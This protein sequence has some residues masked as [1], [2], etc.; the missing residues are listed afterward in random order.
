MKVFHWSLSDSKSP[1]VSRTLLSILAYLSNAVL[2][3]LSAPFISNSSSPFINLLVTIPRAPIIIGITV[4][5]IIHIFFR[6]LVRLKYLFFFSLY[7]NFT[8]YSAVSAKSTIMQVLF[9]VDYFKVWSSGR[10]WAILLY[11]KIPEE[12]VH[13]ILQ[14]RCWV[15]HIPF[16]RMVKL[17]FLAQFLI[18]HLVPSVMSRLKLFLASFAYYV[19]DRFVSITT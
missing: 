18:D 9:L 17:Q 3:M 5:F 11:L 6:Y 13:L 8:L 2:W 14:D 1:Q 12:F 16:V 19:I 7:Y 10:D 4:T 15:V